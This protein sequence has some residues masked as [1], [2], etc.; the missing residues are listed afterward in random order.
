MRFVCANCL[1]GLALLVLVPAVQACS[2]CCPIPLTYSDELAACDVAVIARLV[3]E[4]TR[5]PKSAPTAGIDVV[6]IL[7]GKGLIDKKLDT[8]P[9]AGLTAANAGGLFLV[10]GTG[11]PHITWS[12]SQPVSARL[13]TYLRQ[14]SRLPQAGRQRLA[15][16][17]EHL[18]DS[19]EGI[20]GDAHLE[21]SRVEYAELKRNK[22]LLVHDQLVAWIRD[23]EMPSSRRRTYL[24][25]LGICGTERDVPMLEGLMNSG[26]R[27][28]RRGFEAILTSYLTLRG[29][30]GLEQIDARYLANPTAEYDETYYAILAVRFQ[31]YEE[32]RISKRRL[33]ASLRH[34]LQRPDLADLVIHDLSKAEDWEVI[35]QVMGLY[36]EADPKESWVRV[37][38]VNYLRACPLPRAKDYLL[39][40]ATIDPQA[41][42]RAYETFELPA[43]KAN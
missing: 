31:L 34:M 2:F 39:E 24:T 32:A 20:A 42:K 36:R 35:D 28:D 29:T 37:P 11:T 40:C 4:R 19:D 7:K 12:I 13:A 33:V 25:M 10:T 9:A 1:L 15:F 23:P 8:I 6:Q 21:L 3:P 38:V 16:F 27:R 30:E 18:E 26:Q 17:C 5:A 43:E 22:D 41:V 14:S